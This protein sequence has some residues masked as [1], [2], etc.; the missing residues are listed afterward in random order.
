MDIQEKIYDEVVLLVKNTSQIN[1]HLKTLNGKVAKH[2]KKI[3]GLVRNRDM[4]AGATVLLSVF[5]TLFVTFVK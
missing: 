3:N 5:W 4:V 1:Q 2:E